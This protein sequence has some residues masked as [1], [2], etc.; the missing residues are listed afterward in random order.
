MKVYEAYC[1]SGLGGLAGG[2]GLAGVGSP[3]IE[4]IMLDGRA[5]GLVPLVVEGA[6]SN[7]SRTGGDVSWAEDMG[8]A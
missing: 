6:R 5:A 2:A 1:R 7:F 8:R 3:N 4:P